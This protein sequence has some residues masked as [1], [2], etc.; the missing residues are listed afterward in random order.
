ML[1]LPFQPHRKWCAGVDSDGCVF[2]SVAVK[3][4][5][6]FHDE[7]IRCWSLEKVGPEVRA[8]SEE[9]NLRSR[10]RGANRFVALCRIM[11]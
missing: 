9:V 5:L 11:V 1:A 7:T 6:F 2:D 4:R 10:W 3:Q 8:L